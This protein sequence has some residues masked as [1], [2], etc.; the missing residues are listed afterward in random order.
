[1]DVLEGTAKAIEANLYIT[2][3]EKDLLVVYQ[4]LKVDIS[5]VRIAVDMFGFMVKVTM[6]DKTK[7]ANHEDLAH[8]SKSRILSKDLTFNVY[9]IVPLS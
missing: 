3:I 4:N 1:M 7:L 9:V 2:N 8:P 5:K 6:V